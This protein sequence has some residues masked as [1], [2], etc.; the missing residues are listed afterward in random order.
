MADE[1][2]LVEVGPAAPRARVLLRRRRIRVARDAGRRGSVSGGGR[3]CGGRH[4]RGVQ[5][6]EGGWRTCCNNYL[7]IIATFFPKYDLS[8]MQCKKYAYILNLIDEDSL[9]R[10]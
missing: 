5:D 2:R 9:V 4:Q 10:W 7:I 8:Q 6:G 3:G 1:R